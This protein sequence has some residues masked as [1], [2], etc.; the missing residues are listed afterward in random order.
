MSQDPRYLEPYL[1]AIRRDGVGFRSLLWASEATQAA[2]FAA[3]ADVVDLT[4]KSILDAGCGRADLV[5]FLRARGIEYAHY[6]GM[7]AIESF[8]EVARERCGHERE[9]I[10]RADF[11]R[12]PGRLYVGADVAVFCG[13]LN[14]LTTEEF[15]NS[16]KHGL[17]AATEGMV[18]NFLCSPLLAHA[19]HLT[20]HQASAVIDF[21]EPMADYLLV[22][23]KYLE[24]DCTIAVRKRPG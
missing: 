16:L 2:R 12:D 4:G 8:A 10:V 20:W 11:V 19:K 24:G 18:F 1:A 14:T 15:Y 21:L 13:S 17:A 7:E 9:M 3:I 5:E 22:R 6:V 23:D